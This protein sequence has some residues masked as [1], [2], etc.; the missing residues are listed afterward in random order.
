MASIAH[1][2]DSLRLMHTPHHTQAHFTEILMRDMAKVDFAADRIFS[3]TVS[4]ECAFCVNDL[5]QHK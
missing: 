5:A 4:S 1:L 2:L 3:Q